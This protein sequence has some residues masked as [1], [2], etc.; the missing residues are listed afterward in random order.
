MSE[1]A[2]I[3]KLTENFA[4]M[5]TYSDA[6]I[7]SI[8][9][10][11]TALNEG[12]LATTTM[13]DIQ[14]KLNQASFKRSRYI[15]H[16]TTLSEY[17][18]AKRIPRGLRIQKPPTLGRQDPEFCQQWC[19][20]LNKASLDL[21]VLIIQHTQKQLAS[22]D[23]EINAHT[24]Q[25]QSMMTPED[26]TK[27]KEEIKVSTDKYEQELNKTK[28]AKF[29][30]DT[31]DYKNDNVYPWLKGPTDDTLRRPHSAGAPTSESSA[32]DLP[33][34]SD[35]DFLDP[36]RAHWETARLYQ[37]TTGPAR[38]TGG[39]RGRGRTREKPA[40]TNL[41]PTRQS[42]RSRKKVTYY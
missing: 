42:E 12:L 20:I 16:G 10:P 31:L 19:Q 39:A 22:I 28:L 9:F 34:D 15:L 17:V 32:S 33:S 4:Q 14:R 40:S 27:L 30:R 2:D 24:A 5:R 3:S 37:H 25:L 26:L 41:R 23:T 1:Y 13:S 36:P 21:T 18:R 7:E 29:R 6:D 11:R 8:L 38:S 35:G